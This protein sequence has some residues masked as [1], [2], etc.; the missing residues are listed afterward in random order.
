MQAITQHVVHEWSFSSARRYADPFNQVELDV[1]FSGPD[2][3]A[4]RVPAFWAG[5]NLWRVRFSAPLAGVYRY[6]TICSDAHTCV[7]SYELYV[8]P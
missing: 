5:G 3:M 1:L 8:R 6:E 4:Q 2:G 7:G